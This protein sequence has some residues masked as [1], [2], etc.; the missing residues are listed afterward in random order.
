MHAMGYLSLHASAVAIDGRAVAFLAPKGFGKSTLAVALAMR[1][2]RLITDDS[3]PVFPHVRPTVTEGIRR[4]RLCTDAAERLLGRRGYP[5]RG[6]DD[7]HVIGGLSDAQLWKGDAPLAVLYLLSSRG[8][9]GSRTVVSRDQLPRR[10]S[11]IAVT[12]QTKVGAL[13]GKAEAGTILDRVVSVVRAIPVYELR[14]RRDFA[15]LHDV[16]EQLGSW[17]MDHGVDP[18]ETVS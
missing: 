11:V 7:K 8:P 15:C 17:Q 4:A 2:A 14:I 13:L 1:G 18:R 10:L 5:A 6:A 9:A 12:R 3:L 16:T